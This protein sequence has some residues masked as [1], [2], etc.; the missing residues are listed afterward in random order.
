MCAELGGSDDKLESLL[1]QH[2]QIMHGIMVNYL[3]RVPSINYLNELAGF[4]IAILASIIQ[5]AKL[6]K[7]KKAS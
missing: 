7:T 4:Y 2:S 6:I 1:I 5:E 3:S